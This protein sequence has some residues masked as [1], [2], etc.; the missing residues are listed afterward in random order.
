MFA[1][2]D[3]GVN[4]GFQTLI[5]FFPERSPSIRNTFF[6]EFVQTLFIYFI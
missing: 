6:P 1:K 3:M 4:Q 5:D 2:G